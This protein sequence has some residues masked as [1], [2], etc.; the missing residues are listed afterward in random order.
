[1]RRPIY[2]RVNSRRKSAPCQAA[3]LPHIV[4]SCGQGLPPIVLFVL[5]SVHL[6][7]ILWF[8]AFRQGPRQPIYCLGIQRRS[9]R[10]P[11]G[12]GNCSSSPTVCVLVS[13]FGGTGGPCDMKSEMY[14]RRPRGERSASSPTLRSP[15]TETRRVTPWSSVTMAVSDSGS[16]ALARLDP[17]GAAGRGGPGT[18]TGL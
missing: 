8:W 10:P 15:V 17:G 5:S 6:V 2:P 9:C 18:R 3:W 13:Q 14:S 4:S 16:L 7:A 12:T 11:S 1:M